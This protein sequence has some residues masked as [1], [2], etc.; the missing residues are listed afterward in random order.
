MGSVTLIEN[1]RLLPHD[2]RMSFITNSQ[3][4]I[5]DVFSFSYPLALETKLVFQVFGLS[6][7]KKH[8]FDQ[9]ARK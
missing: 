7:K 4:Q 2:L 1:R 6:F 9:V 5:Q 8:E 3:E